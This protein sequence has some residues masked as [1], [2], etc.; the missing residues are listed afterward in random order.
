VTAG[1]VAAGHPLTAE[2][3]AQILREGGNAFD[4]AVCA[5]L[6]SLTVES[7]LTG[8]GA[9]GF[10]LAHPAG[11]E[12]RLLDFFVEVGG[13][14]I[15]PARRGEL[16]A[17]DI[18]FDETLQRFNIG[19][20]SC[21]VP[22]VPAGMWEAARRF[23]SMPFSELVKPAVRYAREGIEVSAMQAYMFRVLEPILTH[24]PETRVLYAPEGR[25]LGEGETFRFPE[26]GDAL[27]RLAAEGPACIYEGDGV[28]KVC[29]WVCSR[30]GTLSREDFAA[31]RVVDR[32]PVEATYR[33]RDVLTNP[34]PS[35]G[36]ILIAYAFDLLE[37]AGEPLPLDDPD[38][39]ALL[40]E[41]MEEA[42][43]TRTERFHRQLHE[44]GFAER[45]LSGGHLDQAREQ[46]VKR[47]E[48]HDRAPSAATESGS[49]STTHISVVDAEGN[50]AA[51]TCSNGTGSGVLPPGTG[52]HLNNM[53]GEEDLNPLGFHKQ[54]P[55]MRVTSMMAPTVV[56][57]DGEVELALGSAGSNRLR[58]A[59]TQVIRYVVDY[60]FDVDKAIRHARMHYEGG[61]LHA[62]RGFSEPALQELERRG[63]QLL[64]WKGVNLFFGGAQAVY[65][66][67][68]TGELA[69]AGDPRRGGAAAASS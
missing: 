22:G 66:D 59:I 52:M 11:G 55:G 42:Q 34:P 4:A 25:L 41:V 10:L 27:E 14:G 30:G 40:A 46:I 26:L 17:V 23:G 1:V 67:L 29:D 12:D 28:D 49:G 35:S 20:A 5:V 60:G 58:S 63:Y 65:R 31:Y 6:S 8:L 54:A 68:T 37:R 57:K 50:A 51:V 2:A 24:Y 64:R 33:G 3:G 7:Q 56:L 47:L 69:G 9:G 61:V 45:F 21:G 16:V 43:R 53:L 38:G 39:L 62:E 36:G 48:A 32:E 44:P 13:S 19:P 15:D 18:L